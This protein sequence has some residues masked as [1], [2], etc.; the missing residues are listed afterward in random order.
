[1]ATWLGIGKAYKETIRMK[2]KN[3]QSEHV[4]M[5]D[6]PEAMDGRSRLTHT[7]KEDNRITSNIN[8][9]G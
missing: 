7:S 6:L 2:G 8:V 3:Y 9:K 4:A 5:I 1:M